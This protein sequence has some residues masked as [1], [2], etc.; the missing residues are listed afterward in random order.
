MKKLAVGEYR[1][2]A[3]YL[4]NEDEYYAPATGRVRYYRTLAAVKR[5]IDREIKR[6]PKNG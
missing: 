2:F 4:R 6:K 1:G 5:A 3:I